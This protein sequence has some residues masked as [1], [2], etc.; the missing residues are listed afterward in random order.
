MCRDAIYRV[1]PH[2]IRPDYVRPI[3]SVLR[4]AREADAGRADAINR[5]PTPYTFPGRGLA[6]ARGA[7]AINRVPT[8]Y[9]D[10]RLSSERG[11]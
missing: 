9:E 5:V 11:Y 10:R 7:D 1:R 8:Q 4:Q 3:A 6:G 2:R